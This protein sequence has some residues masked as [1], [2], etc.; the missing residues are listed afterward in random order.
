[1]KKNISIINS[2]E[3]EFSSLRNLDFYLDITHPILFSFKSNGKSYIGYVTKYSRLRKKIDLLISEVNYS[4]IIELL[5]QQISI[6]S[7]MTK[8]KM[9][10]SISS[11]KL[12][13]QVDLDKIKELLPSES[14]I[15]DESI[16]N[17]ININ[18]SLRI[19]RERKKEA[20]LKDIH[21]N[22]IA[23]KDLE[24]KLTFEISQ[25]IFKFQDQKEKFEKFEEISHNNQKLT[26]QN[27]YKF[28]KIMEQKKYKDSTENFKLI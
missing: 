3:K 12:S 13:H 2:L 10:L 1:M 6:N 4:D 26:Y 17:K 28:D 20:E 16:P 9:I 24:K 21:F 5:T 19:A 7:L 18:K 8:Y 15:L 14:F 23:G 22:R 25:S 11:D 27:Y